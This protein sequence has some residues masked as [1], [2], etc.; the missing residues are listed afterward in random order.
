MPL[1]VI[2]ITYIMQLFLV[3]CQSPFIYTIEICFT[4]VAAKKGYKDSI[5]CTQ[6][7]MKKLQ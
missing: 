3:D 6:S 1:A 2:A 4:S 7:L 5:Y